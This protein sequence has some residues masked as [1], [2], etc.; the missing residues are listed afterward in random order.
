MLIL[1]TTSQS[2]AR[3]ANIKNASLDV[4]AIASAID[5]Y[6]VK[7][8]QLPDTL[9]ELVP[10]EIRELRK[11]PWGRDYVY[12]RSGTDY[13]IKSAGADGQ[14]GTSDDYSSKEPA[15]PSRSGCGW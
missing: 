4:K 12:L 10:N 6:R 11:D 3:S 2:A 9:Q 7:H 14:L 13:E 8:G 1:L 15:Q 5:V